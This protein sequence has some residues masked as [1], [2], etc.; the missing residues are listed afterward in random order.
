VW[1]ILLPHTQQGTSAEHLHTPP[2]LVSFFI[3]MKISIGNKSQKKDII[4][5]IQI[6]IENG[7]NVYSDE[8]EYYVDVLTDGLTYRA[9]DAIFLTVNQSVKKVN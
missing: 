9:P 7:Y 6:N 3:Y 4:K 1:V 2:T 5:I 8:N